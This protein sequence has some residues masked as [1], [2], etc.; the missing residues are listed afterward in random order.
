MRHADR[1]AVYKSDNVDIALLTCALSRIGAVPALLSPSLTPAVVGRLLARTVR[2]APR[3]AG[4]SA[5]QVLTGPTMVH[6][7]QIAT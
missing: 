6:N 1:V 5:P 4:R 2:P 7:G 3:L